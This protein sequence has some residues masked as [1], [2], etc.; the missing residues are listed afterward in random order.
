MWELDCEESWAPKNWCFWTVVLEKTLASPLGCKEIQ[1]V[2]P[3][4]DQSWV[5][6]G[7]TDVE[8]KTPILWPPHAKSW[9][10]GKDPDAGRDWGQ[11][12]KGTTEDEM[13]GWHHQ[14]DAHE[15]GWS[16]G[17][18]DGQGGLA[19]RV[20]H[21]WVTELNWIFYI[22][23]RRKT[24][25]SILFLKIYL[26]LWEIAKEKFSD[27][28]KTC[29]HLIDLTFSSAC[30]NP[31]THPNNFTSFLHCQITNSNQ[32]SICSR[33]VKQFCTSEFTKRSR[34]KLLCLTANVST[35][36][37]LKWFLSLATLF[38]FAFLFIGL[39][40]HMLHMFNIIFQLLYT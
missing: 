3:K 11:E 21:D 25:V 31:C 33:K 9:L 4:G 24:G 7:M 14:L 5:F 29:N 37:Y 22:D 32:N 34:S 10:I 1:P 18:G 23:L 26:A 20:G 35:W 16:P 15:F 12:E 2:H 38:S 36:Y 28:Q 8:A 27:Y 30:M 13:A 19:C 39:Q 17:V 6:I 40:H